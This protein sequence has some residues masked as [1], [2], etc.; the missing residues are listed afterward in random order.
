MAAAKK[1][2]AKPPAE[3]DS[4]AR[5]PGNVLAGRAN[6]RRVITVNDDL[7]LPFS[8]LAERRGTNASELIR[9]MI[10]IEI[11]EAR[12]AGELPPRRMAS[13]ADRKS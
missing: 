11:H 7:W 8:D 4:P 5:K 10:V 9:Q 6:P 3:A 13:G 2:S 12:K 1:T